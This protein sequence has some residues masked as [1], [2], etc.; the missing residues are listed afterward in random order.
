MNMTGF[1]RI[2]S[3]GSYV[4]E[5]KISSEE[6]MD[7]IQS[8]TRFNVPNTWLEDLTGIRSRRF[9]GPDAN[10]SDLAIEAG[11]AALEKCGMDPKD[12]GMVIY[13]GI[14]RDWVE[15]ATSHRVQRQLGCSN[16]ACLDVTNA[17][18]GFTNGM[19][20]GDA[21]IAT[22][23][24]ENVLVVTGE[25]PS[26][27]ALDCIADINK[28]PTQE[29]F[30]QK[31]GGLTTGDA[32]GAVILQRA[33]QHSGVKTYRFSSQGR[34]AELCFYKYDGDGKRCG[35]MLMEKISAAA[36]HLHKSLILDTYKILDW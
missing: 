8:E 4:P 5:Q 7:E 24:A 17:C 21:M 22:G 13:C 31:V 6:L 33:S 1:S 32:G 18:H 3:I 34:Y 25:V 12:I 20:V 23:A 16:A 26:H 9:A 15:P 28:N 27:V 11:R 35:Q 30:Q 2:E 36:I 19:S 29:N 10:P 14:D